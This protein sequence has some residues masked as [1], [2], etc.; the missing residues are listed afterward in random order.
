MQFVSSGCY[1]AF[2][3]LEKAFDRV[4]REVIWWTMRKLCVK[5]WTAKLVL[6]K[7]ENV[8]SRVRF[9]EGLS[10]EFE[11]KVGG[12]HGSVISQLLSSS[13]SGLCHVRFDLESL[14]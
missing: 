4:L 13:C 7:Y 12:H 3:D 5:D 14:E 11:V 9:V 2:V 10:D 6:G 8:R 1:M